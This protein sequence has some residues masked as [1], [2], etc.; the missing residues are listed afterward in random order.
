M[1]HSQYSDWL[2]P[3][4]PHEMPGN[5]PT[6]SFLAVN[7]YLIHRTRPVSQV[8]KVPGKDADAERYA[9]DAARPSE[10]FRE[11]YVTPKGETGLLHKRVIH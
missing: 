8:G 3:R 5:C 11:E 9:A 4:A 7:A 2:D 1:D 6:G 10:L